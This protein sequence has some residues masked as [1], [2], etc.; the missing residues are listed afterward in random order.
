MVERARTTILLAAL[1][2]AA[3]AFVA[4]T[5]THE[6][7]LSQGR[8]SQA[9]VFCT[10]TVST[11]PGMAPFTPPLPVAGVQVAPEPQPVSLE[12]VV[13]HPARGPPATSS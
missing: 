2:A 10:H 13:S 11:A 1:V 4:L 6:H 3:V 5:H 9:C 8:A 7:T 12:V